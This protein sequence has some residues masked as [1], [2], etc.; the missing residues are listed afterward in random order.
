M[1]DIR[2]PLGQMTPDE[3]R[4]HIFWA[5]DEIREYQTFIDDLRA[6]LNSR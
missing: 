2:K 4:D 6:E 3:I 1:K 5:Q